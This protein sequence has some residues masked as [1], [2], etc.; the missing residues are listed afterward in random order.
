MYLINIIMKYI[1]VDAW[2]V[3]CHFSLMDDISLYEYNLFFIELL[4]IYNVVL[5][6]S[7]QQSDSVL[8]IHM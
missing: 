1:H 6:S 2:V 8:F 4:L 3:N 7:V 5:V